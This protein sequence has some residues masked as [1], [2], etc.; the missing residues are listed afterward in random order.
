[1]FKV[2]GNQSPNWLRDVWFMAG[3]QNWLLQ[4]LTNKKIN[5]LQPG[6]E[7]DNMN[8]WEEEAIKHRGQGGKKKYRFKESIFI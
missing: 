7:L 2:I 8:L 5:A 1:M 6:I 4:K 3:L